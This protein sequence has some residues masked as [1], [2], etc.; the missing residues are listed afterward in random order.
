MFDSSHAPQHSADTAHTAAHT[1]HVT[2]PPPAQQQHDEGLAVLSERQQQAEAPAVAS[3]EESG[4]GSESMEYTELL[5]ASSIRTLPP[6]TRCPPPSPSADMELTALLYT[7]PALVTAATRAARR[8]SV[9]G[10][11]ADS[12]G[13]SQSEPA[14][15]AMQSAA[16]SG[17]Q[18]CELYHWLTP[19]TA[20]HMSPLRASVAASSVTDAQAVDVAGSGTST[21]WQSACVEDESSME[22]TEL[23]N[24]IAGCS[25]SDSSSSGQLVP[26]A[27]HDEADGADMEMTAILSK[28]SERSL[29]IALSPFTARSVAS[30]CNISSYVCSPSPP[31]SG[32]ENGRLS[33]RLTRSPTSQCSRTSEGGRR[34]SSR[35]SLTWRGDE[36]RPQQE[37][38]SSPSSSPLR[39]S[40][41]SL[42]PSVRPLLGPSS[43]PL[44][45]QSVAT[46]SR[47]SV[48]CGAV[49]ERTA[50]LTARWLQMMDEQ[51]QHVQQPQ[52]ATS[53]HALQSVRT[54]QRDELDEGEAEDEELLCP[55][56]LSVASSVAVG[57]CTADI[58]AMLEAVLMDGQPTEQAMQ[59]YYQ[60]TNE[61][62]EQQRQK[63]MSERSVG[64]DKDEADTA[65]YTDGQPLSNHSLLSTDLSSSVNPVKLRPSTPLPAHSSHAAAGSPL[66]PRYPVIV[67]ATAPLTNLASVRLSLPSLSAVQPPSAAECAAPVSVGWFLDSAFDLLGVSSMDDSNLHAKLRKRDSS[68]QPAALQPLD[69]S[70]ETTAVDGG[71]DSESLLAAIHRSVL[72][73]EELDELQSACLQLMDVNAQ[74]RDESAERHSALARHTAATAATESAVGRGSLHR[75]LSDIARFAAA[76]TARPVPSPAL[77]RAVSSHYNLC[78]QHARLSWLKWQ[79]ALSGSTVSRTDVACRQLDADCEMAAE[80][81]AMQARLEKVRQTALHDPA[82]DSSRQASLAAHRRYTDGQQRLVELVAQTASQQRLESDMAVSVHERA[83]ALQE[84]ALT[85]QQQRTDTQQRKQVRSLLSALAA[86]SQCR[87]TAATPSHVDIASQA[88]PYLILRCTRSEADSSG[89]KQ[90]QLTRLAGSEQQRHEGLHSLH[91]GLLQALQS[92]VDDLLSR[93]GRQ[94]SLSAVP[95]LVRRCCALVHRAVQ[96]QQSID[97]VSRQY[98][99]RLVVSFVASPAASSEWSIS[100][101]CQSSSRQHQLV[102]RLTASLTVEPRRIGSVMRYE[103][104]AISLKPSPQLESVQRQVSEWMSSGRVDGYG[105]L[106]CIVGKLFNMLSVL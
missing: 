32:A 82:V 50:V 67:P 15:A 37:L 77:C 44:P 60:H 3:T 4:D 75:F 49:G 20:P 62:R 103:L 48:G 66:S 72:A 22:L 64:G 73:G 35:L 71:P 68:F 93:D 65:C 47:A 63:Q 21:G 33:H 90:Y 99:S 24:A 46:A 53:S 27:C 106:Q 38:F 59:T 18:R 54:E 61:R 104:R 40:S 43:A 69:E 95:L 42:S 34:L 88:A 13:S 39:P 96:W 52:H 45:R 10:N 31:L 28:W 25:S 12:D 101:R 9:N 81:E 8:S 89:G 87:I 86:V 30:S 57:D 5:P 1:Q 16:A 7:L 2:Q 17:E 23:F 58:A 11:H 98:G 105:Q 41:V 26:L 83:V 51:Q 100:V 102:C 55:R 29:M 70:D 91:A 6:A 94:V 79:S 78:V 80:V 19:H 56:R 84:A 92:S 85:V 36:H 74:L 97:A 76:D 14:A